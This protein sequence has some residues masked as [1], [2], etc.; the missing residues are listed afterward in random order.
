MIVILHAISNDKK[1]FFKKTK[2]TAELKKY[3]FKN[4]HGC[5]I[6]ISIAG[7]IVLIL[8]F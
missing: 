8:I 4:A 7:E 6:L 3:F 5:V 2:F 1:Y